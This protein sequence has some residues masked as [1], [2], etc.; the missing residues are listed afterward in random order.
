MDRKECLLSLSDRAHRILE[1]GPSYNPVAPK[2]GGWRTHVVDHATREELRTK[3]AAANVDLEVIEEV[4][5]LWRGGA[6][7]DAIPAA[8]RGSFDT[9]IASHVIEHMPDLVGFLI[10]ASRL[11]APTGVVSLAVPDRRY[12]FDYFRPQTMTGDLL[13]AHAARRARH[14]LRTAWNHMAYA[15]MLDG[16]LAWERKPIGRPT[17]IDPFVAAA[18]TYAQYQDGE[19]GAYKDY[20]A[21]Q[22]TPAGFALAILELGQIG[23]INWHVID[24]HAPETFE[25]FVFLGRGVTKFENPAALQAQRLAL[26][27]QQM[28]ETRQQIEFAVQGGS[29]PPPSGFQ[30]A[31]AGK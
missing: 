16:S 10:S 7:E 17:F 19:G 22:F 4:D 9:L 25:F 27:Q 2:A 5:S 13:E 11:L 21:W 30:A 1:I 26:L 14:S 24:T 15:V 20:H 29:L 8:L 12:C 23:V 3:Y 28:L 6:L 31:L 18:V